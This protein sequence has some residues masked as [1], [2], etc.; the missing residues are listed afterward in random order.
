MPFLEVTEDTWF[1]STISLVSCTIE[2]N[3]ESSGYMACNVVIDDDGLSDILTAV[4]EDIRE[5]IHNGATLS[6][7]PYTTDIL[8]SDGIVY[9]DVKTNCRLPYN[10]D[11]SATYDTTLSEWSTYKGLVEVTAYVYYVVDND[12]VYLNG[13]SILEPSLEC[14]TELRL[15][16]TYVPK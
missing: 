13:I 16:G 6:V 3:F 12:C 2:T 10:K 5:E 7:Y 15:L 4:K 1:K 11:Y 8:D 9:L 14:G